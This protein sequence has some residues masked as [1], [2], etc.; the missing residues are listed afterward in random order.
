[1]V[2]ITGIVWNSENRNERQSALILSIDKD[3]PQIAMD[4]GCTHAPL[5]VRAG[6]KVRSRV[7]L[8]RS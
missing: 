6:G 5:G 1:M 8:N 2:G 4:I 7:Y 3:R